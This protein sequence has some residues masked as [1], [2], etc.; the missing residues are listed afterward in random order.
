MEFDFLEYS[1]DRPHEHSAIPET[2]A[3][4]EEPLGLVFRR[5]F[6]EPNDPESRFAFKFPDCLSPLEITVPSRRIVRF[7]PESNQPTVARHPF[8]GGQH[9]MELGDILDRVIGRE[10]RH[11]FVAEFPSQ[12]KRGET[13]AR[14][15]VPRHRLEHHLVVGREIGQL[16]M[17]QGRV[18]E[19]QTT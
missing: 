10:N 8:A 11:H 19:L 4:L 3:W 17:D 12:V 13:N 5:F 2:V 15:R 16:L 7:D 18:Q 1:V 6:R 14:R 9:G